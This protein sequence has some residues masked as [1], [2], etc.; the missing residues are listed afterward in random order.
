MLGDIPYT[1]EPDPYVDGKGPLKLYAL[2]VVFALVHLMGK[3]QLFE[4]V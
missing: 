2:V 1:Q 4:V 3:R